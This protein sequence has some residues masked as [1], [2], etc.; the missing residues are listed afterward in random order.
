MLTLVAKLRTQLGRETRELR[1]EGLIPAVLYG[2]G[3]INKNLAVDAKEFAKLF[4]EAGKSSLVS[5]KIEGEKIDFMVLINDT[6]SDPVSGQFIH[7]DLYQPDLTK[8]IETEVPL[9]FD[10]V[11]VA[12]KDLGG[13]LVKNISE[14]TVKALPADLPREIRVDIS[15]IKTF[16]DV[17][18]VK[19]LSVGA[20]V[21]LL[22]NPEDIVA[23]AMP[24]QK[25]EEELA[26]AI[27]EKVEEVGK[28]EKKEKDVV[29]EEEAAPTAKK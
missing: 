23:L 7:A 28:V 11:S 16:D 29:T 18:L 19:D 5:L 13:T 22:K 12:V 15:R 25:V 4:R 27:E 3:I 1:Q 10:G 6:D 24:V 17:I 14:I 21:E 2:P 8:A 20:K 9:V 26:K